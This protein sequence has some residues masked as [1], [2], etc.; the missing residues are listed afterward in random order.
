MG[1]TI[2]VFK[3]KCEDMEK[4]DETVEK[5]KQL[6]SGEVKDV[7]KIPIGFGIQEIK[8]AVLI[9]EKQDQILDQVQDEIRQIPNIEDLEVEAMTLL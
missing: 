9:P 5:I 2:I 3:V 6:K 7:K 8:I 4:L 1:K